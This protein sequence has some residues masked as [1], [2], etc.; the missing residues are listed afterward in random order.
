MIIQQTP[1]AMGVPSPGVLG[2]LCCKR[3]GKSREG[4]PEA[5]GGGAVILEAGPPS[6]RAQLPP[7]D[8]LQ[9][10]AWVCPSVWNKVSVLCLRRG[11]Q[12]WPGTPA[13]MSL[14]IK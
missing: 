6:L 14:R 4:G 12:E 7:H 13:R 8:V 9:P 10:P 11:R 3:V 2:A 1:P 5:R